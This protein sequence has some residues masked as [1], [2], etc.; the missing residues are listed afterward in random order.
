MTDSVHLG[1]VISLTGNAGLHKQWPRLHEHHNHW[2]WV[3][4]TRIRLRNQIIPS[5]S[6]W[7]KS[8]E[9]TK[10]YLTQM[11]FVINL[12]YWQTRKNSHMCMKVQGRLMQAR[13]IEI[14]QVFAKINKVGYFANWVVCSIWRGKYRSMDNTKNK[15]L[16]TKKWEI[17]GQKVQKTHGSLTEIFWRS[18]KS[19]LIRRE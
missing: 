4:G 3:L 12:C 14:H 10:H 8:N 19:F 9:S 11:L 7:W 18:Q 13:F 17:S 1:L 2:W 16:P 15:K 6:L 5:F